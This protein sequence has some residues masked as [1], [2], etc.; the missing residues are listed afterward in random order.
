MTILDCE[1][2]DHHTNIVPL[3]NMETKVMSTVPMAHEM[4]VTQKQT[5]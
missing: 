5:R 2:I 3:S 1:S 4:S